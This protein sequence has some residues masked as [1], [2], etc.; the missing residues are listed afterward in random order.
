MLPI[1]SYSYAREVPVH[2]AEVRRPA[3][4]WPYVAARSLHLF[5]SFTV[6]PD[7]HTVVWPNGADLAPEL[8]YERAKVVE[9]GD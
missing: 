9:V 3:S 1:G 5:K 2:P 7:I 8:P 4:S 6:N